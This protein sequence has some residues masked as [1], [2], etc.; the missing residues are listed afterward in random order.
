MGP[1]GV[2]WGAFG[3]PG[4]LV[5]ASWGPLEWLNLHSYPHPGSGATV[6]SIG[7]IHEFLESAKTIVP[8]PKLM[9]DG[10]RAKM[11]KSVDVLV[12]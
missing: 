5:G 8:K 9:E 7:Q 3:G 12:S 11:N 1:L 10:T 6:S 4:S 2:Y